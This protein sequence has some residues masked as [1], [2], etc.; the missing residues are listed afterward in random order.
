MAAPQDSE[1]VSPV[2]NPTSPLDYNPTVITVFDVLLI[3]GFVACTAVLL[4]AWLSKT[5]IRSRPW[6]ILM[7]L[8]SFWSIQYLFLLGNQYTDS[9]PPRAV[10]LIQSSFVYAAPPANMFALLGIFLQILLLLVEAVHKKPG[11]EGK[12]SPFIIGLP[13]LTYLVIFSLA[14]VNGIQH[15]EN[16]T[17][18]KDHLTC[19]HASGPSTFI[20][21]SL[22]LI[23]CAL[24][25]IIE[26]VTFS[27]FWRHKEMIHSKT[28]LL[29]F[30]VAIRSA[31]FSLAPLISACIS[32]S[33]IVQISTDAPRTP[34]PDL[35]MAGLP[36]VA[37]LIFGSQR[38][39]IAVWMFW[40]QSPNTF[41][42]MG[43]GKV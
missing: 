43:K 40:R 39:I 9:P 37:G 10:C 4:T 22:V 33:R 31:V 38:D 35:V 27:I 42:E 1:A 32:V 41:A 15:P 19:H 11:L 30:S 17:R 28:R 23:G 34:T 18:S 5:I 29:S 36:L 21:A 16:V 13:F 20:T 12:F 25:F 26:A 6:Y 2:V 8:T 24:T 3:V 14:L 7:G